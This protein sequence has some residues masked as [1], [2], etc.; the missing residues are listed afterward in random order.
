[1]VPVNTANAV[2]DNL[3]IN[4]GFE[5]GTIAPASTGYENGGVEV[6]ETTYIVANSTSVHPSWVEYGPNSGNYMMVV[7]AATASDVTIWQQTVS[8]TPHHDYLWEAY[9]RSSYAENPAQLLFTANGAT[10]MNPTVNVTS[11]WTKISGN[12]NATAGVNSATLRIVDTLHAQSGDDF[13]IDDIVLLDVTPRSAAITSPAPEGVTITDG[14]LELG[15]Y[16]IDDDYDAVQWAV[17]KGVCTAATNNI[18][19]NVDGMNDTFVWAQVPGDPYKYQFS[20]TRDISSWVDGW[21][22]FVFN[23]VEDSGESDIRLTRGFYVANDQDGDGDGVNDNVDM[24][25]NTTPDTDYDPNWLEP[26]GTNRWQV[27]GDFDWYQNKPGAKGVKIATYGHDLDYTYGCNGHQI[28]ELLGEEFGSVMNGHWKFGPSSSVIEDFHSDMSDSVLD[29][30]YFIETKSVASNGIA[31]P[32]SPLAEG[33]TY[34]LKAS[35]TYRFANWG[36]YGIADAKY[37][38][39]S[40]AYNGGT[41]GWVNGATWSSPYQYYLQVMTT[42]GGIGWLEEYNESHLYTATLVGNGSPVSFQILDDAYGD[43]SG[44]ITVDIYAQL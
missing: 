26:W 32:S 18:I 37:N 13:S 1:M 24:C 3:I 15:A 27:Q 7:N 25:E 40:G 28:L 41:A 4:G 14:T 17:R 19:G 11:A 33:V 36:E 30:R 8:V 31:V 43:N 2:G 5:S 38:Y 10:V 9:V 29:G 16:L 39:R 23:P 12:W 44:S 22:C 34:T 6:T 35:G 42:T 20:A 21:Y